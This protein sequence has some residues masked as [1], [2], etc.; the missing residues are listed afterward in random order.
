MKSHTVV[1]VRS[2]SLW[3]SVTTKCTWI[4]FV[5]PDSCSGWEPRDAVTSRSLRAEPYRPWMVQNRISGHASCETN[6]TAMR[7]PPVSAVTSLSRQDA[8]A[9]Y[10]TCRGLYHTCYT[11]HPPYS[12]RFDHLDVCLESKRVTYQIPDLNIILGTLFSNRIICSSLRPHTNS[13]TQGNGSN[14]TENI[15][16]SFPVLARP[17]FREFYCGKYCLVM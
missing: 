10:V 6:V 3:R 16:Y 1:S 14:C 13:Y 7:P 5:R 4:L 15:K 11:P 2:S 9:V 17:L 12:T 8:N